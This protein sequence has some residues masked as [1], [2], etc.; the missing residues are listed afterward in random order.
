MPSRKKS[1]SKPADH[2]P[3]RLQRAAA[4]LLDLPLLGS[5][6]F[7]HLNRELQSGDLRAATVLAR[8]LDALTSDPIQQAVAVSLKGISQAA[9]VDALW[10][11]WMRSRSARLAEVLLA[12]QKPATTP[13]QTRAY[14]LLKLGRIKQLEDAPADLVMALIQACDDPDTQMAGTARQVIG[15]LRQEDAFDILCAHW[16][17]TRNPFLEA[18]ILTAGYLAQNPVNVHILT[19][20]K[21]NQPDQITAGSAEV[22]APLIAASRDPDAEIAARAGYLLRHALSGAALTEFCLQWS[23][24]REPDLEAILVESSLVPRQP[25]PLRLLC[26]LKTGNTEI[27]RN[28]PPRSLEFLMNACQDADPA[29][30]HNARAAIRT[31]QAQES[32]EA[33]CQLFLSGGHL[34]AR[35]IALDAGYLPAK[36]EDRALF[37]FL[38]EQWQEYETLDFD[39]RMLRAVYE[40]A[41]PDL[42]QRIARTV[43]STGRIEFLHILT[44][45]D[46]RLRAGQMDA[47]EA[48]LVVQML[49][50]NQNWGRLWMLAQNLNLRQSVE[51]VRLLT[52]NQWSPAQPD[53]KQLFRQLSQN[54]SQ[55]L[56]LSPEEFSLKLPAAVPLATLKVHGRVNDIAFSPD[57]PVLA[58]ATGS[59]KVVLWDYQRGV[60]R[61]ILTGFAHSVG[62]AAYLQDGQLICAERTNGG[63]RC[64]IIGVKDRQHF[65]IGQHAASVTALV[66]LAGARLL[67][68]SRDLTITLWDVNQRQ[69][70]TEFQADDWPRCA[71]VSPDGQYAALVT[72]QVRLIKLPELDTLDNLPPISAK[73]PGSNRGMARCAAFSPDNADLLTGQ[74]NGQVTHFSR[75]S[76]NQQRLKRLMDKHAGSV[77]GIS[78]LPNRPFVITGGAEGELHL[79]AWPAGSLHSRIPTPL[80]NLTSLE[81][82]PNGKFLATGFG[83][84]AFT[85]WDLRTLDL[86]GVIDLPIA[87]YQPDHLAA[88]ESLAGADPLP[89]DVRG[90]LRYLTALLQYRYRFDIQIAEINHIQPGEFDILLNDPE[91]DSEYNGDHGEPNGSE[92]Q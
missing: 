48:D 18:T 25:P 17:L 56:I 2:E 21:L 60:V 66:P 31:L 72:N 23:R 44:G 84:N 92:Q 50:K 74:V 29:I 12:V 89:A 62:Q 81:I 4:S 64:E 59:R 39:Q 1:P 73:G 7:S 13:A 16:A 75:I 57:Q 6:A 47:G 43:Q 63:G 77:V 82:S 3:N 26:A 51:I 34:E 70:I 30:Q 49:A 42:R 32:R 52:A 65:R 40:A 76:S 88:V 87:R 78:F 15:H 55:P 45:T 38:T 54:A 36:Q 79:H 46:E 28:C 85:L 53:E 67:T 80:P 14:S 61:Q 58:L 37:L 71:A 9:C 24:S 8:S 19:A 22:V 41:G 33:V 20:L 68:A 86:P 83:Q 91:E 10:H 69:K 11:E 35:Q 27:P 5:V 90:T